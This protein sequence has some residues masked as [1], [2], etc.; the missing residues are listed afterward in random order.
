VVVVVE[1]A[2]MVKTLQQ[3]QQ[4]MVVRVL[5]LVSLALQLHTLAEVAVDYGLILPVVILRA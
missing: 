4:E 2:E 1:Q 3:Q 5:T